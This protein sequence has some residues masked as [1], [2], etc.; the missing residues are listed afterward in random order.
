MRYGLENN[1]HWIKNRDVFPVQ[2]S[3]LDEEELFAEVVKDYHIE[4]AKSC[5]FLSRGDADIYRVITKT[6]NFYLKVYRPPKS[7]EETEAE[8]TLV[9]ALSEAEIPVVKPVHRADHQFAAQVPAPEGMRPMLLYEEA[10]PPIPGELDERILSRIGAKVALFHNAADRLDT[11]IGIPEI[12]VDKALQENV[13]YTSQFLSEQKSA[14]LRNVAVRLG[15][16]LRKQ[17][18]N[19]FDFGI[20]HADLVMS[21][22]RMTK[23]GEITLFDFGNAMKTWRAFELAVIYWSL[24]HRYENDR[25]KLWRGFLR[26]YESNRP[27]P[28]GLSENLNV[29]LVFRQISFLGGNCASLPLRLGTEPFESG[30]IENEIK[31]LGQFVDQSG[32]IS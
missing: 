19:T 24:G 5:R 2:S 28:G 14:Y 23:E 9:W 30:F 22:V 15:G 12:D 21:N 4:D 20:C 6:R 32:I 18:R 26:G 7:K 11:H 17:P 10:P 16:F 31:R 29:L 8:A 3:V 13:I 1:K 25:E 27:L